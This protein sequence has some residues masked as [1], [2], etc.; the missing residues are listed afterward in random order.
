MGNP[1]I[2]SLIP[3]SS[4][5]VSVLMKKGLNIE[6]FYT[7]TC[8]S[9]DGWKL[10]INVKL[11]DIG[12]ILV[13]IYAPNNETY[14]IQFCKRL[15]SFINNC[16]YSSSNIIFSRDFICKLDSYTDKSAKILKHIISQ[17]NLVDIWISKNNNTYGLCDAMHLTHPEVEF[18][19][20]S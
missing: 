15:R 16:S 20:F 6:F 1:Y 2:V 3:S 7:H 17:L 19:W 14:G 13:N 5:G 12:F 8:R 4:R 9:N 11:T 18:I 10:S